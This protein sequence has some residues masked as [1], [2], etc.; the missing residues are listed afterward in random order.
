MTQFAALWALADVAI[1]LTVLRRALLAGD[2]QVTS[3][4]FSNAGRAAEGIVTIVASA[5]IC[6]ALA[7]LCKY[8]IRD[9]VKKVKKTRA[10]VE[11]GVEKTDEF[12]HLCCMSYI[13]VVVFSICGPAEFILSLF[14]IF[15]G[16][17][18]IWV[19][20][21][22]LQPDT[23]WIVIVEMI[24]CISEIFIGYILFEF[25][26]WFLKWEEYNVTSLLHHGG[27]LVMGIVMRGVEA[28]PI[29]GAS[30]VGMEVSSPALVV[31]M[32]CRQ[33]DGWKQTSENAFVAFAP[34]FIL[35]RLISY[36]TAL[37]L[38]FK[39]YFSD[40]GLVSPRLMNNAFFHI[41]AWLSLCGGL[42][43]WM[44]SP[45]LFKKMWRKLQS[46]GRREPRATVED[47]KDETE[48]SQSEMVAV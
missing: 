9:W 14:V 38:M 34:W 29:I 43:Q 33:L 21:P 48:V 23:H 17:E 18:N 31:H 47:Q 6:G 30:A 45:N 40:F 39:V 10:A 36:T 26:V 2:G 13:T 32:I 27:F 35:A 15:S 11:H 16:D 3:Y 44:W 19:N 22:S 20:P 42:L 7:Q 4:G 1:V 24:T 41:L 46:G 8:L 12:L 37:A 28:L 25:I 5:I